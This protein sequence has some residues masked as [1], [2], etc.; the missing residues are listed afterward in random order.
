ERV[1]PLNWAPFKL[2]APHPL[3]HVATKWL[4]II[5]GSAIAMTAIMVV[6]LAAMAV[7]LVVIARTDRFG[8]RPLRRGWVCALPVVYLM[9]A[10]PAVLVATGREW[11]NRSEGFEVAGRGAGFFPLHIW[12]S[13]TLTLAL[14]M[15]V[16]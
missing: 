3:F 1:T 6:A 8:W 11:W 10:S 15:Y 16:A 7:A 5:T 9:G 14:A 12:G 2:T 13:P 4:E